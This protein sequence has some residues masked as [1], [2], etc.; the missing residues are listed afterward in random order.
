ML[1]AKE[2]SYIIEEKFRLSVKCDTIHDTESFE[3]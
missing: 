1:I 2:T 3:D